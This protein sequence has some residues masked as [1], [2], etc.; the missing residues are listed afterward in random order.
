MVGDD[1]WNRGF[2]CNAGYIAMRNAG[3]VPVSA[4]APFELLPEDVEEHGL[5]RADEM[6]SVFQDAALRTIVLHE[7]F[8]DLAVNG[9]NRRPRQQPG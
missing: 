5:G 9:Q 3:A 4:P 2:P 7:R 6:E 1:W 8:A